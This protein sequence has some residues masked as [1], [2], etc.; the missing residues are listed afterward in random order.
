M[1]MIHILATR[2]PLP[3]LLEAALLQLHH[4]PRKAPKGATW[5]LLSVVSAVVHLPREAPKGAK[6]GP[7]HQVSLHKNQ[8]RKV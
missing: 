6:W 5:G 7:L 3:F 1:P 2:G 4:L 8:C